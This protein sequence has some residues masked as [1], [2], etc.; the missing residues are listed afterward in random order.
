M[1]DVMWLFGYVFNIFGNPL[2][3]HESWYW[4]GVLS[5]L[6]ISQVRLLWISFHIQL[7]WTAASHSYNAGADLS[8][9]S[10]LTWDQSMSA[11]K[12][13]D[14]L[15]KNNVILGLQWLHVGC[16]G[17]ILKLLQWWKSQTWEIPKGS[18]VLDELSIFAKVKRWIYCGALSWVEATWNDIS[19]FKLLDFPPCQHWVLPG[20]GYLHSLCPAEAAI[21]MDQKRQTK[22]SPEAD[23]ARKTKL[24]AKY[25]RL[26]AVFPGR[27]RGTGWINSCSDREQWHVMVL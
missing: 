17:S 14:S 19:F 13:G 22:G 5:A 27:W 10:F 15:S 3:Q 8:S 26:R 11:F 21:F 2:V 4:F 7:A 16:S 9:Q 18:S 20:P 6:N 24:R 1:S 12:L 23:L 25:A